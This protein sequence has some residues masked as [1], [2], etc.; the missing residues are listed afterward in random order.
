M[1]SFDRKTEAYP[2]GIDTHG[3]RRPRAR[4]VS[5]IRISVAVA[6][7]AVS[8]GI[9]IPGAVPFTL[10]T[11]GVFF[12]LTL[13]GGRHG[14]LAILCYLLLGA[15]GAPVFSGF[16]GGFG[17][18][19]GPTGGYLVG[20][21]PIGLVYTLAEALFGK[22]RF[23]CIASLGAGLM[24]CYLFGTAWFTAVFSRTQDAI[25]FMSALALC[26][27]PFLLPDLVKLAVAVFVAERV[28]RALHI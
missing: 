19:L 24:L 28:K 20:F 25:G 3:T 6:G 2:A 7:I 10:Q 5:L 17:I 13:L 18:L 1:V 4:L 11:F 14:T 23:V 15:F 16:Q 26:V 9:C 21:V 12:S 8:A 22:K 27:Y